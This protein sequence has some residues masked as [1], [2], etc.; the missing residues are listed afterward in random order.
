MFQRLIPALLV[1]LCLA[2]LG[3]CSSTPTHDDSLYQAFGGKTGI[4]KTVT[5]F[6]YQ[7]VDD[8]RINH[9]FAGVNADRLQRRLTNQF[10]QLSGGPCRYKGDSM[11]KVHAGMHLTDA[12]FNALVEDLIT[13]MEERHIPIGAQNR[14][15]AK[16]AP[17]HDAVLGH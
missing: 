2:A 3:A 16:L 6:L 17:M 5:Q 10:C 4:S 8:D 1:A 14:L 13:A 9:Y 7:V 11:R 15:L 12:D